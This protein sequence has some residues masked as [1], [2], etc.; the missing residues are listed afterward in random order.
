[1]RRT[2]IRQ[3][4]RKH[5]VPR[6]QYQCRVV[7]R[8]GTGEAVQSSRVLIVDDNKSIRTAVESV[9]EGIDVQG[10]I[11]AGPEYRAHLARV[12]TRRAVLLAAERA[13][14]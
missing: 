12:F 13:R 14:G 3:H 9:A 6:R 2:L 7:G 8:F 11:H 10:D 4:G 1:M 5:D